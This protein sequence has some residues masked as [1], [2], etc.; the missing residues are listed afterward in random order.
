MKVVLLEDLKGKGKKGDL[1]NVSDGYAANFLI[2]RK[3]AIDANTSILNEISQKK[4]ADELRA[5]KEKEAALQAKDALSTATVKVK[6]K[7]GESGKIFGSVTAKEIAAELTA[8]GY[9]VDKKNI[10]LK[11]PI[12][13]IGREMIEIKLY[14]DIIARVN[15]VV[16][17]E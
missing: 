3:I 9:S 2:P 16:E 13:K 15:L 6:V 8:M 10:I 12:K 7:C 11:E 14:H 5:K 1:I 17:A 4:S